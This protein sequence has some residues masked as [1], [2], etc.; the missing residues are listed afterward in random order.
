MEENEGD[1]REKVDHKGRQ[2]YRGEEKS[3][4]NKKWRRKVMWRVSRELEDSL[5]PCSKKKKMQ[6]LT[7]SPSIS[8]NTH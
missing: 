8:C 4:R 2:D 1:R 5:T 7:F 3:K 6:S